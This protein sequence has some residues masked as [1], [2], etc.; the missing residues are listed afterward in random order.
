MQSDVRRPDDE[1]TLRLIE[2]LGRR[3]IVLVG[4]MGSGKTTV[5]RRIAARLE[6]PFVDADVEIEKAAAKTIAE[7][8]AEHGEA[9]FRDGERRV[10][11]RLLAEGPQVLATGGGAFM[12]AET[13]ASVRAQAVSVWLKADPEVLIQRLRRKTNRPLLANG[14][15]EG[16]I[17]RLVAERYPVY[18]DADITIDSRD[19][20]HDVAAEEIVAVIADRLGIRPSGATP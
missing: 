4:M 6:L 17:R 15:P 1:R 18:A 8:F 9:Y 3:S 19:V 20:P 5:G 13:R 12:N 7:I 11:A 16:T 14:D 10:I 2:V